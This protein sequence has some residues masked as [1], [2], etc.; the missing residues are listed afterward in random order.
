MI[1][2]LSPEKIKAVLEDTNRQNI[3]QLAVTARRL[4]R[5]YFGRAIG[6]YTPLYLS[7]FCSSHCTYCGFHRQHAITRRKLTPVEMHLEMQAISK[8]GTQNILLLTGES[9]QATPLEYLVTAISIAKEYFQG[10]GLEIFPLSEEGYRKLYQAGADSLTLYQETYDRDCYKTVHL[11]GEKQDYMFRRQAP[12]RAAKAGLRQISLGVLLG[13]GPLAEDLFHL[14]EHVQELEKNFPGI[15]YSLSFPRLRTIKTKEFASACID[16]T[17]FVKILCLTRLVFPRAGINLSTRETAALRNRL[18]DICVTRV[19]IGS[20]TGVGGYAADEPSSDP[21]FDIADDR[22][23]S[24]LI[25]HLKDHAFDPVFT[26]WR[27][28]ENF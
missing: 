21:Q 12:E 23:A 10:I 1:S 14:Y 26:D 2:T 28:I 8:L 24:E 22:S 18:L 27:K 9:P 4:T 6:L 7:N 11:A 17:T 3:E 15:E 16:D 13:L 19:S 5:Q 20:K 25:Q